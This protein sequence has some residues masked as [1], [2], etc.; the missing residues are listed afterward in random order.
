M[1]ARDEEERTIEGMSERTKREPAAERCAPAR[2]GWCGG[3]GE[4]LAFYYSSNDG[5]AGWL[6]WVQ[7]GE[8]GF[9]ISLLTFY[10]SHVHFLTVQ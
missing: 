8:C 1:L 6:G 9:R 3:G 7:S 10:N 4:G 5:W 2:C